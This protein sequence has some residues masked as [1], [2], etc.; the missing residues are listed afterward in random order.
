MKYR[1]EIDGLRAVAV[2]PVILFHAGFEWFSGGFIG[3]DVFFVISGYLITTILV[4]DIEKNR[5]S[6]INFYERRARR[7]LPA[8]FF[9]MLTCIPF[10]WVWMLPDQ[11]KDFSKGIVAVSL[12][13]SNVLFWRESG[14]FEAAAE[15]NPL[16]H[17]WSLAVEEQYYLLFPI[18][19]F[20]AWRF[21]K[22]GVFWMI[23]VFTAISLA[24]SEW[25]WRNAPAANFY[26]AP[27]RAWE[28]FAGS[29]SA[30]IVQKR[31]VQASNA[32]SLLGLAAILFAIFAY[33]ET[34]PFPSV[35][36]LVPVLGVVLLV[37]FAKRETIVAKV[38]STK[39]F[40][41]IGLISYSAYLWHQPLF[42]FARIRTVE[43]P[44]LLLMA[45]LASISIL[46]GFISWKYIEQPFR[47][48]GNYISRKAIFT[49][50]ATG[51]AVLISVGILGYQSDGYSSIRFSTQQLAYLS[52]AK[53]SPLRSKCHFPRRE[54][55]LIRSE[56]KYFGENAEIAVVG[57]S[58]ATELAY[59]L[60]KVLEPQNLAVAQHTMSG[61]WH[62]FQ[63]SDEMTSVCQ[64]WH[65][66][67]LDKLI[68]DPN[69][70]TVVLSYRNEAY[71]HEQKYRSSLVEFS[72]SLVAA[73][74]KVVLVL[75]APLPG[76]H[77]GRY[78]A[79]N[80][81]NLSPTVTGRSV[82]K[83]RQ[84]YDAANSL[85]NELDDHVIVLNPV[86]YFCGDVE[87]Y[88]I[89]NGKGLYFD[90]N[91]MSLYGARIIAEAIAGIVTQTT[92]TKS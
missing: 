66:I 38:L 71:L 45:F 26:L 80:F 61:C 82:S 88:V 47:L 37:L 41:G 34:T 72:D 19:L 14:Y 7:I 64:R 27:T 23:V 39:A 48:P 81:K 86:D 22:N 11:M 55:S 69:I 33:D 52:T 32:L 56:C 75:Q 2:I 57:N 60:A 85:R 89:K 84:I 78:L 10:A 12:F 62:N 76:A 3:V 24:L 36:A 67:V 15:E 16:L 51:I 9:V 46:A 65:K 42:A 35:Y 77:I 92:D 68:A 44:S 18:F 43:Q 54:A 70:K 50:S 8:L 4:D 87:C 90:D 30:F 53:N 91:H 5:F 20:L 31:G 21:G 63:V 6:I 74:K 17:T 25:G 79:M 1:A 49:L 58:H 83:W 73:G 40:V 28:L 59:A 13:A 29:V